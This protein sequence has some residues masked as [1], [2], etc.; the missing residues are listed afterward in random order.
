MRPRIVYTQILMTLGQP[1]LGEFKQDKTKWIFY[2]FI[3]FRVII[4]PTLG[5]ALG[6]AIQS[7]EYLILAKSRECRICFL[8]LNL[9]RHFVICIFSCNES[10]FNFINAASY[11]VYLTERFLCFLQIILCEG[12][13]P[14]S[15]R[16]LQHTPTKNCPQVDHF[17][18]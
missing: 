4:V 14:H 2:L 17:T 7:R 10:M 3:L 11:V 9:N 18:V 6:L 5:L 15:T 1:L 12:A 16:L 13:V 8:L